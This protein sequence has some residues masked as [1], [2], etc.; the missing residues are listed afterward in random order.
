M[1]NICSASAAPTIE[2]I[3]NQWHDFARTGNV[4]ALLSLYATDAVFES[5]LVPAILDC[6]SGLLQGHSEIRRFFEEGT[7]RR[8]NDLVRWYRNGKYFTDGHSLVWEYPRQT[9]DGEQVDIFEVMEINAGKIQKHRI[10][11][12]WFGYKLLL[13]TAVAKATSTVGQSSG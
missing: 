11:W 13:G 2:E 7:K 10:Y 8:P 9:P 5:P 12:G 6:N 4:D 3:Y 1:K